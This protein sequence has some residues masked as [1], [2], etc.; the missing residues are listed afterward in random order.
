ME[1]ASDRL[2]SLQQ[3]EP[4]SSLELEQAPR[5]AQPPPRQYQSR[6]QT[7]ASIV[8][9][10]MGTTILA[11]PFGMM[12]AGIASG[13]AITG[14]LG[15]LSCV[16]CLIVVERG[17]AAGHSDFNGSVQAYLGR[18]AMLVAWAFSVAIIL[19]A[20]IVYHILMQETL[21]ALVR[22]ALA[23]GGGSAAWWS[24]VYAA[25]V[26]LA[27]YPICCLKDLSVL[28]RF[29]SLG[30]LFMWFTIIFIS[31]HG[32]HAL[33]ASGGGGG[34][35][36]GAA[37]VQVRLTAGQGAAPYGAGGAFQVVALGT[38]MFAGLGGMMM[39][40]FFLHNCFQPIVRNA[41]DARAVGGD[42][43]TAYAIAG[44][45]YATVGVVGYA[46]LADAGT[47]AGCAYDAAAARAGGGG[48]PCSLAPNFLAA[49]GTSLGD[50][51]G[52]YALSARVSL[53]AQLFTVFPLLLLIIRVQVFGVLRGTPWPG[54][55]A[56]A[57]LNFC[58]MAATF[59]AAAVDAKVS[60]VLRFVGAVGG[61]V[62]VYAVPLAIH[63]A[64]RRLP[65]APAAGGGGDDD[66]ALLRAGLLAGGGASVQDGGDAADGPG[67]PPPGEG[68]AAGGGGGGGGGAAPECAPVP[69]PPSLL[70]DAVDVAVFAVGATFTL[71]QFVP[72]VGG[73]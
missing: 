10:M 70:M 42:M 19:G 58:V 21:Y 12:Q 7:V 16:T 9:T 37:A 14:A 60:E 36:G 3:A 48:S 72:Q 15:A 52:V 40:S 61:I 18:R 53:L 71:V 66:E 49:F 30:F 31:F 54:P 43:R 4:Y 35:G 27:L 67:A 2:L 38:P 13:L 8:N 26:P 17:L 6:L 47:P 32:L 73:S 68:A 62:I 22:T 1:A 5:A 25:L 28:V 59:A 50:A 69:L 33:V 45:L 65:P 46:G 41:A 57:G 24:P 56:V 51:W 55:R 23:V 11:L 63:A 44:G 20:A 39:L 34:G 64:Q 29:N